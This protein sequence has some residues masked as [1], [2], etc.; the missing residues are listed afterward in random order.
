[1]IQTS[2]LWKPHFNATLYKIFSTVT[3]NRPQVTFNRH[4]QSVYE[5]PKRS[6]IAATSQ[7]FFVMIN[8]APDSRRRMCHCLELWVA[9]SHYLCPTNGRRR[10]IIHLLGGERGDWADPQSEDV[11]LYLKEF[12]QLHF[13][14]WKCF[15]FPKWDC[16]STGVDLNMAASWDGRNG[17]KVCVAFYLLV[18]KRWNL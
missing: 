7:K 8:T 1:M 11:R 18:K 13:H 12:R 3:D 15:F 14:T 16:I 17:N 6:F 10:Q 4:F 5:T 9:M 2:S